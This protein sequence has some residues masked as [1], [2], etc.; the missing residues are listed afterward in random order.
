MNRKTRILLLMFL[1][2][3][4]AVL[5][6]RLWPSHDAD[7]GFRMA[8][9]GGDRKIEK[10]EEE[11]PF[12][13]IDLVLGGTA[14]V[15]EKAEGG[16]WSMTPPA[17]AFVDRHRL[18]QLLELFREDLSSVVGAPL[19]DGDLA[20]FGLDQA[21]R[22]LVALK[23]GGSSVAELEIG[24]VQKPEGATGEGDSFVRRPGE[25]RAWR[26]LGRNFRRPF[27]GG[28]DGLRDRKLLAVEASDIVRISL[29]NPG[30]PDVED[31]E[32]VLERV[33]V[34]GDATEQ[35]TAPGRWNFVV[36]EG[37]GPADPQRLVSN[38]VG[39]FAQEWAE[40]L[41]AGLEFGPDD[42][43][44]SLAL[45]NGGE[46]ALRVTPVS[47]DGAWVRVEGTQGVAK[48]SR[49]SGEQLRPR[50]GDFRDKAILG[51]KRDEIRAV[52]LVDGKTR[53]SFVRDGSDFKARAPAGM[54]VSRE[55]VE[56]LLADLESFR[57]E[58]ALSASETRG[59][60]TGLDRT[61]P[62]LTIRRKDGGVATLR[63]G[64]LNA[65]NSHYVSLDGSPVVYLVPR[66]ILSKLR[67]ETEVFRKK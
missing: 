25:A 47:E 20:T 33:H 31:R 36:P 55:P 58:R 1:A 52:E 39:L 27:E 44:V 8:G 37:I 9:W 32:M 18:R 16:R 53:W 35:K 15:L 30:A 49:W 57:V 6:A 21:N 60:D 11:A 19:V 41:P 43:V 45:A 29:H 65:N 50:V 17:G 42:A 7:P 48:V 13:R 4:A 66:W 67:K 54:A 61:S 28:P 12:D 14:I 26:I 3:G 46:A 23:R 22:V 63:I 51:V 59:V 34:P 62:S 40:S 64:S 56:T 2:L 5:V 24:A 10:P 38:L